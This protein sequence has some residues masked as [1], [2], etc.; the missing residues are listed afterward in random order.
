LK[1]DVTVFVWL[2]Q[3]KKIDSHDRINLEPP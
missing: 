1:L 2:D 3:M